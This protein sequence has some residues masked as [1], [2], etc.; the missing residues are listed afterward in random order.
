MIGVHA[1]IGAVDAIAEEAIAQAHGAA[2]SAR[3]P[4]VEVRLLERDR[5]PGG[6][7]GAHV[8]H[9]LG[10]LV[11]RIAARRRA[12]HA[13]LERVGRDADEGH[14]DVH[15][16]L[17]V[18]GERQPVFDRRL[19]EGRDRADGDREEGQGQSAKE[20]PESVQAGPDKWG[21]EGFAVSATLQPVAQKLQNP[22]D[23]ISSP[24]KPRVYAESEPGTG[25]IEGSVTGPIEYVVGPRRS[26]DCSASAHVTVLPE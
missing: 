5:R 24:R 19:R 10:E 21:R 22:P 1:E 6:V 9:V 18:I 25:A 13:D 3:V 26:V 2:V 20:H 14:L 12:A 11:Q 7:L 17:D 16:V 23:P 4:L 15:Q 8:E